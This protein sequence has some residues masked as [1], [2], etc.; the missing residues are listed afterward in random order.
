MPTRPWPCPLVAAGPL[1]SSATR[2]STLVRLGSGRSRRPR[3]ASACLSAFVR[4]SCTIRY[5]ERSSARGSG[6]ASPSMW[7]RTGSPARVT[8]S[9]SES[10]ASRPGWGP[11]SAP[12]PSLR[13]APSRRR[14]SAERGA[15]RLLDSPERVPVLV[16][17]PRQ[18]VPDGSDLE[19][20]HAHRVGDDVVELARD[21]RALLGDRD[22]RG[23]LTLPLRERR[24]HQ[25][26]LALPLREGRAH[27][28]R[29]GLLGALAQGVAG[30]PGD[31]EPEGDEDEVAGRLRTG[32]VD[33]DDHDAPTSTIAR[34]TPAFLVRAGSRAGTRP[35]SRRRRGCRRTRSAG[36]RRTRARRPRPSRRPGRRTG[37][38][39][40]AR[41]GRTRSASAGTASQSVVAG[42][43]GASRP[44]TSS[45]MPAMAR[46]AISSSNQYLPRSRAGLRLTGPERTPR[47]LQ[48]RSYLGRRRNRRGVRGRIRPSDELPFS[49]A[50]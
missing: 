10:R 8:S 39:R 13:I 38:R 15:A 34:P 11:S 20:H 5:A 32:D 18:L 45:S 19:H 16:E 12:S 28:R 21:P 1:P 22:P 17:G 29:L 49:R 43:P 46:T 9:T 36:R 33:D 3:L 6:N 31:H 42:A 48:S 24:A 44:T 25:R 30:D 27:L 50:S 41:S 7:S 37:K 47:A 23:G 40:R 35:P 14:I 2:S 26:G 4:P